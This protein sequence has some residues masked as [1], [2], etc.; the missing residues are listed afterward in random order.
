MAESDDVRVADVRATFRHSAGRLGSRF[1]TAL[2]DEGR[3][4]G[5]RTGTPSRVMVPPKDIGLPGEWVEV[6]PGARLEAYAPVE[7]LAEAGVADDDGSC[8]ALVRLDGADTALLTRLRPGAALG[9]LP[10][11][12]RLV[13]RM[14]EQR[15]GTIADLW[16]EPVGTSA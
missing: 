3:V 8:L 6:G 13:V 11:G 12:Q 2:R 14:A 4:L 5:W 10:V 9:A 7:W 1:L 15:S 16:F